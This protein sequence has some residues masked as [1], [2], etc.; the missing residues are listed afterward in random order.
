MLGVLKAGGGW[1]VL[2]PQQPS[3]RRAQMIDEIQP[4]V[5]LETCFITAPP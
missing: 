5:V 3:A 4:W 2:D 1:L